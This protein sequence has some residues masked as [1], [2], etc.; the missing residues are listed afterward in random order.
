MKGEE[1]EA[2]AEGVEEEKKRKKKVKSGGE[3]GI[4]STDSFGSLNL[5]A[6]TFKA[7]QELN[8]Q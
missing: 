1:A 3:S 6:N 4:M 7:I 8:F 5:S 2:N